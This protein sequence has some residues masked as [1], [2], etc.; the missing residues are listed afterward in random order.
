MLRRPI[1]I[2]PQAH[3][4]PGQHR[5]HVR[6]PVEIPPVPAP[7]RHDE[8]RRARQPP[9]RPIVAGPYRIIDP[10][11]SFRI[12]RA[13]R[14]DIDRQQRPEPPTPSEPDA[15]RDGWIVADLVGGGGVEQHKPARRRLGVPDAR[16]RVP[17]RAAGGE[18][19]GGLEH[20]RTIFYTVLSLL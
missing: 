5:P 14:E 3:R 9:D 7:R 20:V 18:G 2:H 13:Q 4:A 10:A 6:A 12:G 8:I 1:R 17:I 19:G 11:Q 16:Q 15:P